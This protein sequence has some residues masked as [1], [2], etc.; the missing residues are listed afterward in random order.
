MVKAFICNRERVEDVAPGTLDLECEVMS[1]RRDLLL[2]TALL[3]LPDLADLR[4][5]MPS[6]PAPAAPAPKRR[7]VTVRRGRRAASVTAKPLARA[8]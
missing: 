8:N 7:A 6:D 5:A 3:R 4:A 2:R 1:I